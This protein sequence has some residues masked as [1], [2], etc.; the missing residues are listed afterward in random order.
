MHDRYIEI[1]RVETVLEKA[2]TAH[3][4]HFT[5]S[6]QQLGNS[7]MNAALAHDYENY[8]TSLPSAVPLS[9]SLKQL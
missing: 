8:S 3:G 1:L 2:W 9:K 5:Y 4:K 7:W 6:A